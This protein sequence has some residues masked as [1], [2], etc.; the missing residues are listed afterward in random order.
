MSSNTPYDFPDLTAETM[1]IWNTNAEWWDDQIGDGN[2]FQIH[3]I[4]PSTLR[5]LDVKPGQEIL[6]V[7][8][9][10]GRSSR[11]MADRG[12][13]VLAIDHSEKFIERARER[14]E[15]YEDCI[16]YRIVNAADEAP[17]QAL[18][19]GRFDS[20]VCTMALMDMAAISPLLSALPRLLKPAGKFVFSVTHP[21]FNSSD[22]RR[23][24]EGKEAA[25]QY[26]VEHRVSVSRYAT[27]YP[28]LGLGVRGQPRPHYYFH[29]SF[30]TL[31]GAFFA[32]GFVLDGM[33]EPTLPERE[34]DREY[35]FLGFSGVPDI[36]PILV[37][38]MRLLPA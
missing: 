37:A 20:A 19:E 18:G 1:E 14:S 4:E 23:H 15:D 13:R 28:Y 8:C 29:R 35:G 12:A 16:E 27:P 22:N 31:L 17:L 30:S 38:R 2:D 6:D 25:G 24:A 34:A 32:H 11:Q 5:L 36:P 33:E 7:A 3:L 9:G 26:T 21:A 10:A